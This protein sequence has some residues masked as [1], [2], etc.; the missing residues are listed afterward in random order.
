MTGTGVPTIDDVREARSFIAAHLPL[1]TP[2]LRSEG[3]AA[4]LTLDVRLKLESLLPTSAFK[5]R[6]GVNL[7]GRDPTARAG[8]MGAST[9]NHGQSLAWAGRLFSVPVTIFCPVGSNPIKLASM[10]ALG[11][12]V[13]EH[14]ADYDEARLEC[15]RR[16]A[17][18]GARYV[19]S[20]NEPYLIAGVATATLEVLEA[21][22]DVDALVVP[23]GGGSGA[24]GVTVV[25]KALAPRVEVI[26][27]QAEGAPA[28]YLSWRDGQL[29]TTDSART[30]ADGLATRSAFALPQRI[31]RELLDDFVLVS[32]DEL[33]RAMRALLLDAH[34]VAEG[35]GA[36]ATAGA[37][38][39]RDRLRGKRV[40]LWVSGA[41]A[42]GPSL[43]DALAAG[44]LTG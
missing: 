6:G 18:A 25:A 16:A 44:G 2:L 34:V 32:D 4:A 8:V 7:V 24:S 31:L 3:L 14:G 27:V 19:H 21:W 23:I 11:A 1:P 20:G 5:V 43:A 30:F 40:A 22:A 36:A 35:A 37:W 29:R 17:D 9:G 10:R 13:V 33:R 26:G 28:G 41:N 42:T 12:T 39:L 38:K 15:E